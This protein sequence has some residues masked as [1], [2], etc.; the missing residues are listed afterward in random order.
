MSV[1]RKP[2]PGLRERHSR[3]CMSKTGGRCTCSPSI[4]AFVYGRRSG[5]KIRKTFTGQGAK[6]A[7]KQWRADA[8]SALGKGSLTTP[9]RRTLREEAEE[10][11][12][13]AEAGEV[14]TRSG[15]TYKPAV[16]RGVE[17]D[18]R[19]RITPALGA[20]KLSEIQRRDVQALVDRLRADGLSGSKVRGVITSLKIV[21]RRPLEDDEI[22][23]NPA[24]RL[25]LPPPAGRRERVA[26][27]E[28]IEELIAVLPARDRAL[29]ATAYCA[30][31]RRGE[32]RALRWEDLDL[33][34]G[35]PG[36]IVHVRRSWDDK[37][38]PIVPKSAK[39][40]RRVPIPPALRL[41]LLEHMALT[42]R[43]EGLVFGPTASNPFTPSNV[44][45]RSLKAWETANKKRLDK[46]D[47]PLE[48][49]GLHECRHSW[50]SWMH[51]AGFTLER[52]AD[53]AGH[54]STW[55]TDRYRHLLDG[56]EDE[57]ARRQ[58][59]YLVRRA[60]WVETAASIA[61]QRR[62]TPQLEAEPTS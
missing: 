37:T 14:F 61:H 54:S 31:L 1:T 21:L 22:Q 57:A 39:S 48:P 6:S 44:R 50:V 13:R 20:A 56:H 29:Y 42:G 36:G 4:E 5:R 33:P 41:Y 11:H 28:Q 51:D 58:D 7:A 40:E 25:R 34:R 18:F 59:E 43:R 26:S 46:G 47:P 27:P 35:E 60:R 12:R 32:L 45:K 53:Y 15:R 8:L 17:A 62:H 10:W 52:I 30:G 9:V 2:T 19:L 49:I 3:T 24:E 16:I 38:G 55:M 23:T